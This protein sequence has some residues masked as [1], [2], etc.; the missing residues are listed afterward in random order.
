MAR[1]GSLGRPGTSAKR[2]ITEAATRGALRWRRIWEAMSLPRSFSEVARVTMMPV[3]AEMSRAGIWATRPSPTV[4]SENW[5]AAS[6]KVEAVLHD[7]DDEAADDVDDDDDAG[8]RWRR[9]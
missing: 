3:A 9:P 1:K 4:R 2:P 8:R 6:V 5:W 7:A